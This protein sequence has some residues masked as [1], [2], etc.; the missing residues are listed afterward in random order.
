MYMCGNSLCCTAENTNVNQVY[1]NKKSIFKKDTES[2]LKSL[3]LASMTYFSSYT[4]GIF[5]Y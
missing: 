2:E 3:M 1:T 4:A 5:G